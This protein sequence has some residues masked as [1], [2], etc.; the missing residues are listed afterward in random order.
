MQDGATE[1]I[2]G[3]FVGT[4]ADA[5]TFDGKI[6]CV[7]ASWPLDGNPAALWIPILHID[8][9]ASP[10][11]ERA[12]PQ[13]LD[14]VAREIGLRVRPVLVHCREGRER[15]P[16][17]VAYYLVA[18]GRAWCMHEAYKTLREQ[19]PQVVDRSAWLPEEFR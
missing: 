19:R 12:L 10:F 18:T 6:I 14:I 3:L 7:L 1:V 15:S 5:R 9:D 17:A 16:L 13:Q 11:V 4:V 8:H 2:P